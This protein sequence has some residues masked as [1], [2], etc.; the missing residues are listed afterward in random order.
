M[1]R[2]QTWADKRE[3]GNKCERE[4]EREREMG[5]GNES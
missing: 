2:P 4:R 1:A 5:R 3:T